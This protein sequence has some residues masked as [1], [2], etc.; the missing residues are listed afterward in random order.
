MARRLLVAV[1]LTLAGLGLLA[2]A[3][4]PR[5]MFGFPFHSVPMRATIVDNAVEQLGS[6]ETAMHM[7]TL[8]WH[9]VFEGRPYDARYLAECKVRL[10]NPERAVGDL[11]AG[12]TMTV[13]IDAHRPDA[14]APREDGPLGND[15]GQVLLGVALVVAGI[16]TAAVSA[17]RRRR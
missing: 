4:L 6:G 2:T 17:M 7:C 3:S 8:H 12:D 11:R 5:Y 10:W 9:Y 1:L 15:P 14:A 13:W 16:V